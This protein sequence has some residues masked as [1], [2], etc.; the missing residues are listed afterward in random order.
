MSLDLRLF[1][2]IANIEQRGKKL[3][4]LTLEGRY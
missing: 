2:E 4:K 1:G 3:G